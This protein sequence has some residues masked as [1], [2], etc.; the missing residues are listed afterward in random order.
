MGQVRS[1]ESQAYVPLFT[2]DP[3]DERDEANSRRSYKP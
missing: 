1:H 2:D 3:P